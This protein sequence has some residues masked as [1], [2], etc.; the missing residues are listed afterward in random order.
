MLMLPASGITIQ[1][2][3]CL[4]KRV[5]CVNTHAIDPWQDPFTRPEPVDFGPLEPSWQPR[6][7]FAGAYDE[8]ERES[9]HPRLRGDFDYR[10]YQV[11][12]SAHWQPGC[13]KRERQFRWAV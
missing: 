7:R 10:F 13:L 8:V 3:A 4:V 11:S 12:T 9:R 5:G 1:A 2:T 6:L